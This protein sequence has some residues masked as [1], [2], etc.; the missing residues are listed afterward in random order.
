MPIDAMNGCSSL[1]VANVEPDGMLRPICARR[2]AFGFSSK[3]TMVPSRSNRKMPICVAVSA[4]TGCAAMV[5]SAPVVLV[6]VNQRRVIHPVQ[7]VAGEH[8]LVFGVVLREVAHSLTDGVG[9]SLIP[10]RVVRRLLGSQNLDEAARETVEPVG[11]EMCR[12]S[13]A[14]LNCVRTKMRRMSACRQPLIGTSMSRYLPPIGTAGFDRVAVSGNSRDPCPPP[15]MMA[16]VSLDFTP[17]QAIS[18]PISA[19]LPC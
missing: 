3:A 8:Q 5:M 14:E 7:V 13:D 17:L 19:A 11:P 10:V 12:L 1:C 15:R 2:S 16:S 6:R 18:K 4:S 9:G